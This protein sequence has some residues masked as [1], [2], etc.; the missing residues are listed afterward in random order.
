MNLKNV[1]V[2]V[3]S[4]VFF[5]AFSEDEETVVAPTAPDCTSLTATLLAEGLAFNSMLEGTTT[6]DSTVCDSYVDAAQAFLDGGCTMCEADE[7]ACL[8][9][10]SNEDICCDEMTQ[11][12]IT[13][14]SA[15]CASGTGM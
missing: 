11:Q 3:I 10:E 12:D 6:W 2:L 8:E 9:D 1:I 15:I 13:E 5:S 4:L 7:P 14:M